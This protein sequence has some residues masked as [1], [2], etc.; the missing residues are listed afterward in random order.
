MYQWT[1]SD[2]LRLHPATTPPPAQA[3][4]RPRRLGSPASSRT[5]T[6]RPSGRVTGA[7]SRGLAIPNAN[8]SGGPGLAY[9]AAKPAQP[10]MS[11][12]SIMVDGDRRGAIAMLA[13][14]PALLFIVWLLHAL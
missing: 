1:A 4:P 5:S 3:P 2:W 14:V 13:L 6:I 10:R 12:Q 9:G 8:A 11:S 7:G